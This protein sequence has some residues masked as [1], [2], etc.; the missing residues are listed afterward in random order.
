MGAKVTIECEDSFDGNLLII[1]KRGSGKTTHIKRIIRCLLQNDYYQD[2]II[3]I[4]NSSQI[5]T[6]TNDFNGIFVTTDFEN[7]QKQDYKI[8][9]VDD[10]QIGSYDPTKKYCIALQC[11]V[12]GIDEFDFKG[13]VQFSDHYYSVRKES[14]DKFGHLAFESFDDFLKTMNT[15]KAYE[16][17]VISGNCKSIGKN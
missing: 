2:D 10:G 8:I 3:I 13:L 5:A 7:V 15:L 17:L 14:Y 6:Y 4:T 11:Y 12:E 16:F 1:G 9:I